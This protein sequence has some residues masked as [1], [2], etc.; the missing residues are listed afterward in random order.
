MKA[1]S[2]DIIMYTTKKILLEKFIVPGFSF[3]FDISNM[4][5]GDLLPNNG[6]NCLK[7]IALNV[8]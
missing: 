4:D 6:F 3:A 7:L 5:V 8:Q 1:L 2:I